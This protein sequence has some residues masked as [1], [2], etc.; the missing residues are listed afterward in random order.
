MALVD[1]TDVPRKGDCVLETDWC[2]KAKALGAD[3]EM[4]SWIRSVAKTQMAHMKRRKC[5][6]APRQRFGKYQIG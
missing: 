2:D 1:S 3:R 4:I 5:R 6:L